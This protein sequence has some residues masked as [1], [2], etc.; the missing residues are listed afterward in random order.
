MEYPEFLVVAVALV[1]PGVIPLRLQA[2]GRAAQAAM[3][4]LLLRSFT[5][6][7]FNFAA[8]KDRN[9]LPRR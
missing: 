8:G 9:R 5:D 1:S 3:G 2:L 6:E 4:S 7:S